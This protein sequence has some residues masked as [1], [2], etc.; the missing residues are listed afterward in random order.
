MAPGSTGWDSGHLHVVMESQMAWKPDLRAL[1][2][3][4]AVDLVLVLQRA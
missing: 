1:S 3:G 4:E 2:P